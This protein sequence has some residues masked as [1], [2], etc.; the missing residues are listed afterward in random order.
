MNDRERKTRKERNR[1]LTFLCPSRSFLHSFNSYTTDTLSISPPNTV[2]ELNPTLTASTSS[3]SL[4]WLTP[5]RNP[6]KARR[7]KKKCR[8]HRHYPSSPQ[9]QPSPSTAVQFTTHGT[10][11]QQVTSAP[12]RLAQGHTGGI[13]ETRSLRRNMGA[14]GEAV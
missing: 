14:V 6:K 11:R 12:S 4:F 8:H 9:A 3:T 5:V 7:T 2:S 13:R 10:A 1:K